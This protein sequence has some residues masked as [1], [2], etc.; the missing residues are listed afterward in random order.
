[1]KGNKMNKFLLIC[2][3]AYAPFALAGKLTQDSKLVQMCGACHGVDGNSSRPTAPNLAGQLRGYLSQQLREFKTHERVDEKM[4]GAIDPLSESDIRDLAE[5]YSAQEPRPSAPDESLDPALIA[6]G[7]SLYR[8]EI[9]RRVGLTCVDCH[10]DNAE[11]QE[12]RRAVGMQDFPRLAGQKHDYLV[13]RLKK[14]ASRQVGY[15][16]LGM[17]VVAASL[18]EDEINELA[19]YLSSL[20]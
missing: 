1:L 4:A 9:T 10:G 5:Y 18:T 17:N 13:S 8:R 11:G 16:L 7:K 15:G 3:A 12:N 19:A 2:M 14:Y 6:N 20:K